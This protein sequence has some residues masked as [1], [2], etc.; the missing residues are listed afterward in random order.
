MTNWHPNVINVRG[1]RR[2]VSSSEEEEEE[3]QGR[4]ATPRAP[5]KKKS[6]TTLAPAPCIPSLGGRHVTV[7]SI[8]LLLSIWVKLT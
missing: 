3:E 2:I 4:T 1:C 7:V 5:I 8:N 6:Y